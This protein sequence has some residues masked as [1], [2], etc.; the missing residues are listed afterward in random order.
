MVISR[1]TG[2][3]E[4]FRAVLARHRSALEVAH[5]V[6]VEPWATQSVKPHSVRAS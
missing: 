6:V 2:R 4:K 1:F 5:A 3:G